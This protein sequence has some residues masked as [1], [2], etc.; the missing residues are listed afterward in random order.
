MS[1]AVFV[2]SASI[3]AFFGVL[4]AVVAVAAVAAPVRYWKAVMAGVV[5]GFLY[6]L[7]S[8]ALIFYLGVV[9]RLVALL[10]LAQLGLIAPI[11]VSVLLAILAGAIAG[12]A[13]G[14]FATRD[15]SGTRKCAM[16]GA[17]FGLVLGVANAALPL[18]VGDVVIP[19]IEAVGLQRPRAVVYGAATMAGGIII[20]LVLAFIAFR[21]I[22]RRWGTVPPAIGTC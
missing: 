10:A 15:S 20:D 1:L 8:V 2:V 4:T 6:G 14:A 17:A 18:V 16:F 5:V 22:R 21:L 12:A 19:A 9:G 7:A 3:W 11:V 13:A